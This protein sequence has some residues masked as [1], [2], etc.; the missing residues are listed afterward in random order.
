MVKRLGLGLVA[1]GLVGVVVW[2]W[3]SPR[4]T[5]PPGSADLLPDR[6]VVVAPKV[7]GVVL[8]NDTRDAR[9]GRATPVFVECVLTNPTERALLMQLSA[10]APEVRGEDGAPIPIEWERVGAVPASIEA[11]TSIGVR[12]IATSPLPVGRLEVGVSGVAEAADPEV[13]RVLVDAAGV[14]VADAADADADEAA[15]IQLLAWRGQT[16]AA[17]AR[18]EAALSSAP[19][20][21]VLQL[22]R[23]DVLRDLGR[24]AEAVAQYSRLAEAIDAR[25]RVRGD[26]AAE[27][28]FWL[29]DRLT[30]R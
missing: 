18:I 24:E 7:G 8:V 11:G 30:A 21:L 13:A 28:P 2:F 9:L 10:L 17:L 22:W 15:A 3:A 20:A 14:T 6:R 29:A 5:M 26:D 23:A 1:I 16:D 25:Q 12:W 27:L 19:D 4:P